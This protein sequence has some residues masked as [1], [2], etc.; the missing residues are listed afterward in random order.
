[1]IL[2]GSYTSLTG[3][4]APF[5]TRNGP[6]FSTLMVTLGFL[7]RQH[8][9]KVSSA[10]ALGLIALGMCI[11]FAEVVWLSKFDTAFT[12]MISCL[13]LRYGEW[14]RLCGF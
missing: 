14:A 7:I 12:S 10:K 3:L 2:A 6:F 4:E 1:M 9:W 8:E 5:F 13:V 11:H